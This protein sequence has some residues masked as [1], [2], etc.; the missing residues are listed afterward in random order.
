MVAAC[1]GGD[2]DDAPPVDAAENRRHVFVTSTTYGG[3]LARASGTPLDNETDDAGL[4]G[5]NKL[6]QTSAEAGGLDGT[7]KAI[8]AQPNGGLDALAD[9]G[10][11]Y[12]LDN[13]L[14]F[15]NRAQLKTTP[16]ASISIDEQK[17]SLTMAATRCVWTGVQAGGAPVP[18][19]SAPDPDDATA[20]L[21]PWTFAGTDQMGVVGALEATD[22]KWIYNGAT[23][24]AGPCH[25]YCIEQ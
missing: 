10:P 4:V 9:V 14:A 11:W 23:S 7:W 3:D 25:L 24:C 20:S 13:K 16:L 2:G 22:S 18:G 5:A 15:N 12:L 19:C 8:V 1:G 6:C 21:G 17:R